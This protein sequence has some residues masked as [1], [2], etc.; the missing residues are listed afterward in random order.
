M[1]TLTCYGE[2]SENTAAGDSKQGQ[3]GGWGLIR[4]GRREEMMLKLIIE[5]NLYVCSQLQQER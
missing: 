5:L 2:E 3:E 1:F 4:R